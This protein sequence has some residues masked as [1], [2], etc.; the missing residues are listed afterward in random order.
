MLRERETGQYLAQGTVIMGTLHPPAPAG[1]DLK[2]C[3]SQSENTLQH[4]RGNGHTMT[5]SQTKSHTSAPKF[6]VLK[7]QYSLSIFLHTYS[8]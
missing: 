2:L 4:A 5:I 7:Y 8:I 1:I 6:N 3:P